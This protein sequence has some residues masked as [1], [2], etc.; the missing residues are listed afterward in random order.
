MVTTIVQ[1]ALTLFDGAVFDTRVKV[2]CPACGGVLSGYDSRK[3]KFACVHDEK[4]DHV[5]TV[6]VKRF[7]CKSCGTL[8]N[9]DGP[10]YPHT[11]IGSPVIDLCVTF[12]RASGYGRAAR[13]LAAM[14]ICMD[15]MECRH[16]AMTPVRPVLYIQIFGFPMPH[17]ITS[18]S[19]LAAR[20]SEGSSIP[21]AEM[22]AACG[23]PSA[24]RALPDTPP[25]EKREDR[26]KEE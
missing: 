14:G 10:F 22:L 2:T 15:R 8:C 18:L 25:L 23:F 1:N 9:A 26:D 16:Y 4:G 17:T 21:G 12:S 3:R 5:I 20:F 24:Y 11:R 13:N 7:F 19:S 6:T